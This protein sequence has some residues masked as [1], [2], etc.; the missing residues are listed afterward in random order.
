M[1]GAPKY[2][3]TNTN[4]TNKTNEAIVGYKIIE[5]EIAFESNF[6]T[7]LSVYFPKKV[8]IKNRN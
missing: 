4:G 6:S 8:L 5:R 2:S 1:I 3:A 7:A